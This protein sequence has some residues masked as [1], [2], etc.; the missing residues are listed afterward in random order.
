MSEQNESAIVILVPQAQEMVRSVRQ[1]YDLG[2]APVPAHITVLYPFKQPDQLTPVVVS[3][4]GSLFACYEPFRFSLAELGT[5]P[6]TLYLAPTP[7]DPFVELTRAVYHRFP[8]TPPYA[9]LH[10]EIVPHLTLAG[11][12]EELPF[13][14]EVREVE[15]ALCPLLPI[16]VAATEVQLMDNSCGA[17]CVHTT[18]ALGAS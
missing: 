3:D 4:L 12:P 9:G 18:F 16:R 17:W 1:R 15:E 10:D 2:P 7:L 11:V 13:E 6:Q 14:R 8:E 5:F